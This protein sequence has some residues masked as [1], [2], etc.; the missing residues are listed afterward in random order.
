MTSPTQTT[1][2]STGPTRGCHRSIDSLLEKSSRLCIE[3]SGWSRGIIATD[4]SGV[5]TDRNE[6]MVR[7]NKKE[8]RF[9]NIRRL[10]Y[11]KY[12]IIAILDYLIIR[13]RMTGNRAGDS[14][15]EGYADERVPLLSRLDVRGR[16][17]LR[18]REEPRASE[19]R[20]PRHVDNPHEAGGRPRLDDRREVPEGDEEGILEE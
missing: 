6:E 1:R 3:E 19:G 4:S 11:L 9:E 2:P 17:G 15:V 5:E 12:Y 8:R 13:A 14:D 16:Q 18:R 20:A 7:P 10:I